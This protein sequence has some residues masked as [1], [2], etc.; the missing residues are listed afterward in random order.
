MTALAIAMLAEL[1]MGGAVVAAE[2]RGC[3][4]HEQVAV[5]CTVRERARRTGLT[6]VAVMTA[7]GQ[8]A[9][10]VGPPRMRLRHIVA[11]ARGR[12]GECPTW[13]EGATHFVTRRRWPAVEARWLTQLEVVESGRTSHVF[14]WPREG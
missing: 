7:S 9:R 4:E 14:L 13:A 10:P 1:L 12:G 11:Y 8:Y 3:H 5:A 6:P 2:C